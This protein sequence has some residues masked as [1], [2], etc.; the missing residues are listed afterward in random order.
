LPEPFVDFKAGLPQ[1]PLETPPV[2][3]NERLDFRSQ[4]AEL[5]AAR[6]NIKTALN[7][8][9]MVALPGHAP[10][11]K[12]RDPEACRLM[13][14]EDENTELNRETFIAQ[15]HPEDREHGQ[16]SIESA[17][18]G[19]KAVD[20]EFRVCLPGG[21]IRW[22]LAKGMRLIEE[23]RARDYF[24]LQD[25]SQ[26]K[27]AE[28]LLLQKTQELALANQKL[29]R[30]SA[31]IAHDLKNP[32]ASISMIADLLG[33][34]H[35]SVEGGKKVTLLKSVTRR[36]SHLIDEL[37]QFA[38]AGALEELPKERVSFGVLIESVKSN[39]AAAITETQANLIIET[40]LP[41][42]HGNSSQLF[43]LLQNLISNGLKYR[44]DRVPELRIGSSEESNQWTIWIQDNGLGLDR[45]KSQKLF[46]AFQRFHT[47]IEGT[48]LGLAICKRIVERHGGKIWVESEVG[49]GSRFS[50]TL[51][52]P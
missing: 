52:K 46:E 47:G 29:E 43:Q 38:K 31:V 8:A 39:L 21:G 50:F 36:M 14:I 44:S 13:G 51:A 49:V 26:R 41:E 37:L 15:M 25:I 33:R 48:G 19:G 4:N 3:L 28:E 23:N 12:F 6:K 35:L 22:I 11:F 40:E 45:T 2:E 10:D 27:R 1:F 32:L 34:S 9:G 16:K 18:T 5:E 7:A 17:L 30:F 24:V 20:V 42:V